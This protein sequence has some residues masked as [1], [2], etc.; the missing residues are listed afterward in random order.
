MTIA[1]TII[2]RSVSSFMRVAVKE[3]IEQMIQE[4]PK[5]KGKFK[6]LAA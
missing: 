5:L 6:S 4:D 1:A 2:D 3:K